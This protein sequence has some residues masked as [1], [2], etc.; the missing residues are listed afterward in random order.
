MATN[1]TGALMDDETKGKLE[2]IGKS[3]KALEDA[4]G[5]QAKLNTQLE[6]VRNQI[7]TDLLAGETIEPGVIRGRLALIAGRDKSSRKPEDY[8][9]TLESKT[10]PAAD[11]QWKLEVNDRYQKAV[12]TIISLSTAAVGAPFVFL[13]DIH[14][15]Q[16]I[17]HV[18]T[19]PAYCGWS[20]LGMS[21]VSAVVYYFFSAKWVKLALV[22]HADFFWIPLG[23]GFVEVVLDISYFLMM[24]GF[25]AGVYY[26]VQFMLTYVPQ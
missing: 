5:A 25:L 16:A 19:S 2:A 7:K 17:R 10:G 4:N 14:G 1:L 18:L 8:D 11:E 21:I 22:N 3:L 20:L 23:K 24:A 12:G 9:L 15:N 6:Q 26:M 13:K